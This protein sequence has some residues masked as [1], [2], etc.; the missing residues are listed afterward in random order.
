LRNLCSLFLTFVVLGGLLVGCSTGGQSYEADIMKWHLIGP[1][2]VDQV[3]GSSISKEGTVYI[4][5]DIGGIYKSNDW[6][7]SWKSINQGL[8]N[9]DITTPVLIDPS[10]ER[11][12]YIGTRGGFYKSINGGESWVPKWEGMGNGRPAYSSLSA[13]IGSINLDPENPNVIYAG[14]GYRPSSEGTPEVNKIEWSGDIYRSSNNGETW[15]VIY[16]LG[17]GVKIRHIYLSTSET[18]YI[19]TNSGLFK[20]NDAGQSWEKILSVTARYIA[21]HPGNSDIVYLAAGKEGVYKSQ[22]AGKNWTDINTGLI[23]RASNTSAHE[24]N[25]SMIAID[26]DNTDTIYAI[27]STWGVGG[28]VY[29]SINGG[30]LWEKITR[31]S[32]E[33][34]TNV[35]VAWLKSSPRVNAI[36][37][38]QQNSNRIFIG[39]SRYIYK[40]EDGGNSWRQLI[41]RKVTDDTWTHRGINVFGQT[42]V[43]GIDPL[44]S[45]RLY[46][47]TADHGLVK[48][49]D[50]GRS[51]KQSV[52]GMEYV[53]NVFDIAIDAKKSEIVYVIN[54]KVGFEVS[55]VAKS[56]DYGESWV[57]M[58]NGLK[59]TL[60]NTI[61]LDTGN[62]DVVYIGGKDGIYK[63]EDG[64]INWVQKGEE[65]KSVTVHK[66]VFY[67]D[68]RH[69]IFAATDKGLYKTIDGGNTWNRTHLS[70][71]NL[72]TIIIDPN[73]KDAIYV[74]AVQDGMRGLQ[75]GVYMSLNG[76]KEWQR[77]L[78]VRRIESMGIVPNRPNI[79]Y[80]VSNDH[81]Y[82][83]ESSGEGVFRS[84]DGGVSWQGFN[85]GLP[86]LR[87]FN[88]N[89]APYFP[90]RLYLSSNGSGAYVTTD[91]IM[92]LTS[93]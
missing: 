3:S 61:L 79:I 36:A 27:N 45:N 39:T 37:I 71:M 78:N 66:L 8:K 77:V 28:G 49:I 64:G 85:N 47:G 69:T 42:K 35:E 73:Q 92:A 90:Y 30:S 1:G 17:K 67:P 24:D 72:F 2:D 40:T 21:T 87:G 34:S 80:A 10:N 52:N 68:N 9:Y 88:I 41:S 50:G 16:S 11:I 22:D 83:D 48:S 18:I 84:V 55:G 86:V 63:T 93:R 58:N 25:Y 81:Q 56:Y 75:G 43:V 32:L 46:I 76:G 33:D 5:T 38:D 13:C 12:L 20:S 7:E 89:I 15:R 82:H 6:G 60:Y 54:G 74:G 62:S 19:S 51:W 26:T 53:D 65:L 91:P 70:E 4:S 14:F 29:R 23:L 59:E 44:D 57:Q 31:W